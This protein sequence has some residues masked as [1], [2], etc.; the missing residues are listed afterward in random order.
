ME[1]KKGDI[2]RCIV[3]SRNFIKKTYNH[4]S[5]TDE[6]RIIRSERL[7]YISNF[8]LAKNSDRYSHCVIHNKSLIK[9]LAKR[10]EGCCC[11]LK[12]EYHIKNGKIIDGSG[13]WISKLKT[14][15]K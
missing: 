1:H 14:F 3:C 8:K 4:I 12:D 2:I 6:C 10:C 9:V 11:D 5:C 7:Y 15:F 13:S